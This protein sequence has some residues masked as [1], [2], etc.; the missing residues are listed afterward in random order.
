[1]KNIVVLNGSTRRNGKLDKLISSFKL[2][3]EKKGHK[4]KEIFTSELSFSGELFSNDQ[5]DISDLYHI[6]AIFNESNAYTDYLKVI[7]QS[8]VIIF[9]T[10]IYW[11]TISGSLKLA[12]DY[13]QPLQQALGYRN[14]IKESALLVVAGGNDYSQPL[15]WYHGFK[16]YLGWYNHGEVLG[17]DKLEE[18]A[19]LGRTI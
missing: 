13:L 15:N 6:D 17:A 4:V 11:W 5:R 14:F 9:A 7:H 2:G 8:D 1:M 18:A 16:N 19:K 3:A 12:V 10:P